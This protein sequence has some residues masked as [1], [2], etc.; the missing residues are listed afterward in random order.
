LA[1]SDCDARS[2]KGMAIRDD[3]RQRIIDSAFL[4]GVAS[5]AIDGFAELV[6]A[7]PLLVLRPGQI[8]ALAQAATAH[9]LAQDPDDLL[10]NLV[11]HGAAG[12]TASG[13]VLAAV[14]LLVHGVVK[15]GIVVALFRGSRRVYP[16]AIAAIGAFL[17]LQVVQLVLT[18]SVGIGVLTVLDAI[19][20]WLTWREWRHGRTLHEVWRGVVLGWLP[21][22]HGRP[23]DVTRAP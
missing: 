23:G 17:V 3:T 11:M 2:V 12:L 22:R 20:L 4:L 8:S 1:E 10:A 14:Y 6:V 18:P 15:L 21:R 9:E 19:V 13:S 7:L 16:W 5:K